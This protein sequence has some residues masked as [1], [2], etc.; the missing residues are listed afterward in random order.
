M[1]PITPNRPQ[2]P[3]AVALLLLTGAGTWLGQRLPG[4]LRAAEPAASAGARPAVAPAAT[5]LAANPDSAVAA[6]PSEV[7]PIAH[8]TARTAA[9]EPG[10]PPRPLRYSRL[11]NG[12]V[13]RRYT[14][15]VAGEPVTAELGWVR[16][17]S[18]TGRFYQWRSG[19]EYVLGESDHG[20]VGLALPV[21]RSAPDYRAAG[22]W[23]LARVPGVLLSGMWVDSSGQRHPFQLR[24]SYHGAV[25]YT[26]QALTL[27]GG[28]PATDVANDCRVPRIRQEY[29]QVRG[30][31]AGQ[32]ALRPLRQPLLAVRRRELL[33]NLEPDGR[34]AYGVAV[35]LNDFN[36]LSYQT[37][38]LADPFGGRP[39]C[40]SKSFLLDLRT[41]KLLTIASQFRPDYELPLRR[42]LT[43]QLLRQRLS[44]DDDEDWLWQHTDEPAA[45]PLADLPRPERETLTEEDLLLTGEGLEATYSPF[46]IFAQP[47]GRPPATVL[48]PYRALR[49]LVRPGTP[50]AR[51]LAAR[52]L[53][54]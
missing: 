20:P 11:A 35:R 27:S 41:G 23:R 28:K 12:L 43:A 34:T 15:V 46:S 48:V 37:T 38:Y 16:P 49:P 1:N 5:P 10:C 6:A 18:I 14:G 44:D 26:I 19:A 25:P 13:Y 8:D 40:G 42:L 30:A 54:R 2:W 45:P 31:A 7:A 39:Q 21:R 32:A 47:G 17:D 3:T 52:G 50:L 36:L 33:A 51:M 4:S 53:G 22:T 9:A 24:E 29:L